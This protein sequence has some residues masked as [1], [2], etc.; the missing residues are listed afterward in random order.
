MTKQNNIKKEEL[1]EIYKKK[2]DKIRIELEAM[3]YG[4][5]S[6]ALLRKE[7]DLIKQFYSELLILT[8]N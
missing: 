3:P 7:E 1:I 5:I 8:N 2:L 6:K 4:G